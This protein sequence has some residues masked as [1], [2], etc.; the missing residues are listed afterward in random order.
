ML[1]NPNPQTPPA[2]ERVAGKAGGRGRIQ[3]HTL[4]PTTSHMGLRFIIRP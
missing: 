4:P 3:R 1:D 2:S